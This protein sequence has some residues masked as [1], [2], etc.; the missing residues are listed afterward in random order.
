[1]FTDVRHFSSN[2]NSSS[3]SSSSSSNS[4]SSNSSSDSNSNVIIVMFYRFGSTVDLVARGM[5]ISISKR[6]A[7]SH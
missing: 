5:H 4:S 3:S 7:S 6:N 1:M 2:S